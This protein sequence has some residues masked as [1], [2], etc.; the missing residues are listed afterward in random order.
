LQ[1]K[2]AI[3][4]GGASVILAAYLLARKGYQVTGLE[5]EPILGGHIR[6]LNKNVFSNQKHCDRILEQLNYRLGH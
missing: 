2:I 3:I 5:K 6:T 1:I 4:S